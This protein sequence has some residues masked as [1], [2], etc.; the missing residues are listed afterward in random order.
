MKRRQKCSFY[1]RYWIELALKSCNYLGSPSFWLK[2]PLIVIPQ[3]A[4]LQNPGATAPAIPDSKKDEPQILIPEGRAY[5]FDET[6]SE[7]EEG[8]VEEM[9]SDEE[10]HSPRSIKR[11][12]SLSRRVFT[13]LSPPAPDPLGH[14]TSQSNIAPKKLTSSTLHKVILVS[15]IVFLLLTIVIT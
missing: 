7:R 9:S 12:Q 11:T 5:H 1:E 14:I 13:P 4:P 10:E 6:L 2:T 15:G 8:F 3:P